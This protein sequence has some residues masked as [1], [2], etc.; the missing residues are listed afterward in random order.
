MDQEVADELAKSFQKMFT[1]ENEI[2]IPQWTEG[3]HSRL[4]TMYNTSI[5][6]SSD[7][8]LDKLQNVRPDKSSGPEGVH[9]L[10]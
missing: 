7:S 2:G 4:R 9:R 3:Q 8:V 10:L 5:D 6:L 1:R